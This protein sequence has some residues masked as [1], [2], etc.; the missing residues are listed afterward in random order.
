MNEL[1]L[2]E[3]EPDENLYQQLPTTQI[4]GEEDDEDETEPLLEHAPRP[5]RDERFLGTFTM[6]CILCI[7]LAIGLFAVKAALPDQY[8]QV[9][10]AYKEVIWQDVN[11]TEKINEAQQ[12]ISN[13]VGQL[14]PIPR[15]TDSQNSEA[16]SGP[17]SSDPSSS[18]AV[19]SQADTSSD[20]ASGAG[21][22]ENTVSGTSSEPPDSA[23]Y[24]PVVFTGKKTVPL[25]GT[26][27]SMFGYRSHPVSGSDDFHMGVD[28]AAEEGT[29]VKAA[30]AGKVT[31]ADYNEDYGNYITI[32]HEQGLVTRYAH[33]SKLLVKQG[34]KVKTGKK[35]AKVG[36]TGNSTGYHLHFEVEQNGRRADP[37]TLFPELNNG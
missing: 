6:Q 36:S 29:V 20:A 35:I 32:E 15:G 27:T 25:T 33:C 7:V 4:L 8:Q 12:A 11:F 22:E 23:T 28:I 19:S 31:A 18:D 16:S 21:G 2:R 1:R 24:A 17:A 5:K 9:A 3:E 26:V 14:K 10:G 30:A 13:F 37:L 34:D